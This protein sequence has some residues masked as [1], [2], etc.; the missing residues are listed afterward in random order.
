[1]G[2]FFCQS[3]LGNL[4]RCPSQNL[5]L[6][7]MFVVSVLI[8]GLYTQQTKMRIK[9]SSPTGFLETSFLLFYFFICGSAVFFFMLNFG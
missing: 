7:M 4:A 8:V 9:S 2:Q 5:Q 1:M 6:F 3:F